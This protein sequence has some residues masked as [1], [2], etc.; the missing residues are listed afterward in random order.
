MQLFEYR[1]LWQPSH[2]IVSGFTKGANSQQNIS[3]K[4]KIK[5]IFNAHIIQHL[6]INTKIKFTIESSQFKLPWQ[7]KHHTI[8]DFTKMTY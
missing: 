5:L 6:I 8:S 4:Q 2:Q 1:L 7:P 3:L